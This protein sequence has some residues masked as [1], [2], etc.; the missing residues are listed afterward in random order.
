MLLITSAVMIWGSKVGKLLD[1]RHIKEYAEALRALGMADVKVSAPNF[2]FFI[3]THTLTAR[4]QS[5][6]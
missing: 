4:K 6:S 1:I 5:P 2:S 3:P